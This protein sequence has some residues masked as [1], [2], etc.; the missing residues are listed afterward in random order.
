MSPLGGVVVRSS[1]SYG[2]RVRWVLCMEWEKRCGR[3]SRWPPCPHF[4]RLA[5]AAVKSSAF[6]LP[7]REGD[8]AGPLLSWRRRGARCPR[9]CS[10]P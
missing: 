8:V 2:W 5:R 10:P 3:F 7:R 4:E 1:A 9:R 6:A